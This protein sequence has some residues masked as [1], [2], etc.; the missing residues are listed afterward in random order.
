MQKYKVKCKKNQ[1]RIVSDKEHSR[2]SSGSGKSS[3]SSWCS[4]WSFIMR[5]EALAW[6]NYVNI[7]ILCSVDY[8]FCVFTSSSV[9][10]KYL[11]K[12]SMRLIPVISTDK[13]KENEEINSWEK[14]KGKIHGNR[15]VLLK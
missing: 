13:F 9:L 10:A 2:R 1:I 11:G 6:D 5:E 3:L 15:N 7:L 12:R 4:L 8:T 14:R